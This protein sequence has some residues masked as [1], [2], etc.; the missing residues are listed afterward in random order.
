MGTSWI[1][2]WLWLTLLAPAIDSGPEV[3]ASGQSIRLEFPAGPGALDSFFS[4]LRELDRGQAH[5]KVRIAHFGD[6]H[7]AADLLTGRLRSRFQMRFGDGGR[8][9]LFP[10]KPHRSYRP[11]GA[12][13]GQSG[14]WEV[15]NPLYVGTSKR[16]KAGRGVFGLGGFGVCALE[17]GAE[18]WAELSGNPSLMDVELYFARRPGGGRFQVQA[19]SQTAIEETAKASAESLGL[20]ELTV[21]PEEPPRVQVVSM[22]GENC[23]FGLTMEP[24]GRGIVYDSLGINGARLTTLRDFGEPFLRQSLGHR[25]YDLVI[26]AYGTNEAYSRNFTASAFRKGASEALTLMRSILPETSCILVGPPL[27]GRRSHGEVLVNENLPSA[28]DV[29]RDLAREYRCAFFDQQLF[30]GGPERF[31]DWIDR[32]ALV[33]ESLQRDLGLKLDRDLVEAAGKSGFALFAGDLVHL[34]S[35]GYRILADLLFDAVLASYEEYLLRSTLESNAGTAGQL[36]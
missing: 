14:S 15:C 26:L 34:R 31:I 20:L 32:P 33:V 5:D 24:Q 3:S 11:Q 22:E 16:E 6:S 1:L 21:G 23:F 35:S 36:P 4:Q 30:M 29:L 25:N 28:V 19:G 2:A 10:G 13:T 27:F 17:D 18:F 12:T 8:G 7:I 9:F